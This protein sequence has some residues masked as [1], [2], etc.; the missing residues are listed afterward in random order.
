[1]PPRERFGHSSKSVRVPFTRIQKVASRA[2]VASKATSAHSYATCE[3]DY[4]AVDVIRR[5]ERL[6]YLPFVARAVVI[7]L[8]EYSD[9]N[10]TTEG[11]QVTTSDRIRLGI[12]VDLDH[13]GLVVPVVR[14]ADELTVSGLGATIADLATRARAK[15]LILDDVAGATFTITNPGGFGTYLSFPIINQPEVAILSSDGVRKSVVADPDSGGLAI[16]RI[17]YLGLAYDARAV[18]SGTAAQ[19]LHRV[20]MLIEHSD[21]GAQL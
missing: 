4:T 7:A 14:N 3:C 21:W 9:L 18:Q 17:G 11:E 8:R 12:A 5:R 13:H 19:F 2:L 16:R 1:M 10:A 15:K 6:T 20:A